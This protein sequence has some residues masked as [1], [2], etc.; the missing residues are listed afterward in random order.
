[1]THIT[2]INNLPI[3]AFCFIIKVMKTSDAAYLATASE[4]S[5][6]FNKLYSTF[7]TRTIK[8][9]E[10]IYLA[11]SEPTVAHAVK[12]GYVRSY[13]HND[14]F[15]E[16]SVSFVVKHELFPIAWLFSKSTTALFN[17]VA[18]TDCELYIIDPKRFHEILREYPALSSKILTH[19]VSDNVTKMLEIQ[20]LEQSS[21]ASKLIATFEYFSL[22]YGTKLLKD[23]VRID[24][25]LTQK[26][27]ASFTGLARET[28]TSEI[29]KLK[30][31]NAIAVKK[32][33]YTLNIVKL[34]SLNDAVNTD[35]ISL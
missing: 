25:P 8:K 14:N 23:L 18:H 20:A 6:E 4:I 3:F 10:S 27:L 7:R 33:Y 16:R 28:V 35:N 29:I 13:T 30:R 24:I 34:Q 11:D 32:K 17:Y 26:D 9:G 15:E 1:M 22:C 21:A 5:N 31:I 2:F 12:T 19:I